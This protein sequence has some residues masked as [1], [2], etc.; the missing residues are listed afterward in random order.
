MR[1]RGECATGHVILVLLIIMR[2][3]RRPRANLAYPVYTYI[4]Q[5]YALRA[6]L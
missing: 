4:H 6:G 2:R 5:C 3:S 1:A